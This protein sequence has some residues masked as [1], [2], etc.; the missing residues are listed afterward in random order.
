MTRKAKKTVVTPSLSPWM[1]CIWRGEVER[2][3]YALVRHTLPTPTR[4][5]ALFVE[6]TGA[7]C[8]RVYPEFIKTKRD[9]VVS[10]L[11][12]AEPTIVNTR[13][14]DMRDYFIRR[15]L[16]IGGDAQA[17]EALGVQKP[18]TEVVEAEVNPAKAKELDD[19]YIRA[20]KLLE[21]PEDDMRARY[22]HLNRGLQAMNLRNRLR[23]KG[24]N[25]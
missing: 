16:L 6:F 4:V 19:L 23:A 20:A 9:Q 2:C 25:V 1:L 21:V 17:Y 10:S 5:E 24:H 13:V 7:V 8:H 14:E 18:V 3:H 11:S 12:F 22:S 15:L